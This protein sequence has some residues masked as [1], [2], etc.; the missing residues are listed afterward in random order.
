MINNIISPKTLSLA[1]A[2]RTLLEPIRLL[3]LAE[4]VAMRIPK[5]TNGGQM[6]M[7]IMKMKL[8]CKSSEELVAAVRNDTTA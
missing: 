1:S 6:L 7:G 8:F 3:R 5:A 2:S 4:N